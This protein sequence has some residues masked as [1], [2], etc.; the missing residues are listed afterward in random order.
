MWQSFLRLECEYISSR[1]IVF[2]YK[3]A[4]GRCILLHIAVNILFGGLKCNQLILLASYMPLTKCKWREVGMWRETGQWREVG[5]W[6]ETG[7]WRAVVNSLHWQVEGTWQ[8]TETPKSV[9]G[10]WLYASGNIK[11]LMFQI[12]AKL[13]LSIN[14]LCFLHICIIKT[15]ASHFQSFE[16]NFLDMRPNKASNLKLRTKPKWEL[17]NVMKNWKLWLKYLVYMPY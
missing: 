14:S 12:N 4:A 15:Q 8:L 10:L 2:T 13:K 11:H 1:H 6:R 3:K 5:K 17:E 16:V 7:Q 9:D